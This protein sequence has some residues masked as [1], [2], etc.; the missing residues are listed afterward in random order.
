MLAAL[1]WKEYGDDLIAR[2]ALAK[3]ALAIRDGRCP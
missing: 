1:R 3:A 2:S